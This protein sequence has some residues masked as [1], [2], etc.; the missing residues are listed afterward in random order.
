MHSANKQYPPQDDPRD[1]NTDDRK[2]LHTNPQSQNEYPNELERKPMKTD[3][4][5]GYTE[6]E[7]GDVYIALKEGA[8][9]A[10][11]ADSTSDQDPGE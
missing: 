5:R 1:D 2:E 11:N 8:E 4:T 6:D 7:Y 9:L 10:D 3:H